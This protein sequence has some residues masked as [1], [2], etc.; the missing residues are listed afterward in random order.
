MKPS[1]FLFDL[2]GTLVDTEALWTKAIVD[3]VVSRGGKTTYEEILPSVIGRNWLD[4]DRS[5]HDRFPEIG[6]SSPMEDA[7]EL[8]RFYE[9][10]A[11]NPSSMRIEGSIAFFRTVSKI[12]P[13]AIVSGSPHDD[14]VAA[15][16]LC[17]IDD[18]LSLVLGAGEYAAGKPSPSGFLKAAELLNVVPADCVVVEDSTVGVRAGVAAGMKVI[19]LDR[20]ALVPQTFKG[21]TWRV[22]DLSEID[23]GKEFA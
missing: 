14:V 23:V 8:R 11:N 20:A 16:K 9:A 15:A 7:V 13:C 22:K 18:R 17:G 3:F 6:E 1:A 12:A 21:E 4:I 19:A 2:D 5:L 10:Y